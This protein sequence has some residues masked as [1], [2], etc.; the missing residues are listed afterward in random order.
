MHSSEPRNGSRRFLLWFLLGHLMLGGFYVILDRTGYLPPPPFAKS[1]SFDAKAVWLRDHA[2]LREPIDLLAL[3]SSM[4]LNNFNSQ[5]VF[6]ALPGQHYVNGS[7]WGLK[8]RHID[9]LFRFLNERDR[10][11]TLVVC[12][13]IVDFRTDEDEIPVQ[14]PHAGLLA[15]Y[16]DDGSKALCE[17]LLFSGRYFVGNMKKMRFLTERNDDY[18]SL[19]FDRGGGVPFASRGFAIDSSRWEG[20]FLEHVVIDERNYTAL[21]DLARYCRARGIGMVLCTTPAR[22]QALSYLPAGVLAGHMARLRTMASADNFLLLEAD[23][24]HFDDAMFV[25]WGHLN[26]VGA[27]RYTATMLDSMARAGVF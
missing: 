3:G 26:E 22:R 17:L 20:K 25:D 23:N 12:S 4:T 15:Y 13:S 2:R 16:L 6:D 27:K 19:R 8:M 1:I 18:Q 5:T 9:Q 11:S 10:I 14:V 7:S 21:H 24:N